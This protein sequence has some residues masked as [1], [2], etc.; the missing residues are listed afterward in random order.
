MDEARVTMDGVSLHD[1]D[2]KSSIKTAQT[3]LQTAIADALLTAAYV[4]YCGPLSQTLRDGLLSDWLSRCKTANYVNET[5]ANGSSLLPDSPQTRHPLAP[6]DSYSVEEIVGVGELMQELERCGM[7]T[8]SCSRHN[9]AL[10]Y[11]C[12][13]CRGP[14]QRWTLLIDPDDQAESC[15]RYIL[16]RVPA[17]NS[18]ASSSREFAGLVHLDYVIRLPIDEVLKRCLEDIKKIKFLSW[19]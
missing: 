10:V 5:A 12:L 16:Q 2:W 4:I 3:A 14:R 8:D 17:R 13:F 15:I 1:V 9:M 19:S 18:S 7:L 11:S 6:S